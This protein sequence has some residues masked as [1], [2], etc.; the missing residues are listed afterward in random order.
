VILQVAAELGICGVVVFLFLVA[1]AGTATM[2]A[3]R[4]LRRAQPGKRRRGRKSARDS[5]A[6]VLTPAEINFF[7]T[8][9]AAM[10]AALAGWFVCALFASVA[11]NWTF[12]YLLALAAA[13][14][15]ALLM[16]LPPRAPRHAVAEIRQWEAAHA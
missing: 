15:D 6:P 4:L 12:Y 8:H 7:D 1:R 11:Y 10:I 16:R 13:P 9:T 5:A 2:T 3:R 14:R